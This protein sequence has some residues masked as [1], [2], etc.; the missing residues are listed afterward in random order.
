MKL[1]YEK[2]NDYAKTSAPKVEKTT[3]PR[4][5]NEI[6]V[7]GFANGKV[8]EVGGTI[9]EV[10]LAV[11]ASEDAEETLVDEI[12]FVTFEDNEDAFG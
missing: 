4:S 9:K 10:A 11:G 1:C 8:L 7:G 6:K 3:V 12:I 2:W 5:A